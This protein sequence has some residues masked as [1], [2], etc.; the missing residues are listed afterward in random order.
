MAIKGQAYLAIAGPII[1]AQAASLAALYMARSPL[2]TAA[3]N[4]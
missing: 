3:Q 4:S 1:D 2:S